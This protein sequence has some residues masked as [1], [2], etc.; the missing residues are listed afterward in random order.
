LACLL[1]QAA[2]A[3]VG[4]AAAMVYEFLKSG[5]RNEKESL[6]DWLFYRSIDADNDAIQDIERF[7]KCII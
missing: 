3:H 6:E 5:D 4:V 7:E 2:L 1:L